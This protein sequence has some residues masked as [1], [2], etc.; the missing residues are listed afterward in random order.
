MDAVQGDERMD[1]ERGERMSNVVIR[2][3]GTQRG[4]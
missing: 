3:A 4:R 2:D 1:V